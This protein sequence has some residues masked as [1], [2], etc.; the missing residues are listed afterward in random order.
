MPKKKTADEELPPEDTIESLAFILV[1]FAHS[2]NPYINKQESYD[3][4]VDELANS[5]FS[6]ENATRC[7]ALCRITIGTP[8]SKYDH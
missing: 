4:L 6:E 5:G 1:E 8:E 2:V 7:G 3:A